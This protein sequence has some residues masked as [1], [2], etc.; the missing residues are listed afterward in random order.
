MITDTIREMLGHPGLLPVD[1]A[2]LSDT[3]NL[4][5]AGLTSH[6]SVTLMLLLEDAFDIEFP[7]ELLKRRT[8]ESIATIAESIRS[9][10]GESV[11]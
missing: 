9:V 11:A 5:T 1:V 4:Y 6:A 7:Q 2:T 3:D 10:V 8:F